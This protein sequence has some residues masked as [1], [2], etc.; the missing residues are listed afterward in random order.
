MTLKLFEMFAGYGG[1]SFALERLGL[2]YECIGYSEIDKNA[3]KCYNLNHPNRKNFG[4]CRSINP[5]E[6]PNFDLLTGGFPCQPFSVAGQNMGMNDCRG[7]LFYDIIRIVSVKHPKYILL[8]NVPGMLSKT[9]IQTFNLI[10][11]ML[12][13]QGY[14]VKWNILN[15]CDYGLPQVRKRIWIVC[16]RKDIYSSFMFP[17]VEFRQVLLESILDNVNVFLPTESMFHVLCDKNVIWLNRMYN[18]FVVPYNTPTIVH[19]SMNGRRCKTVGEPMFTLTTRDRHGIV[20]KDESGI[21]VR[22]LTPNECF[23]LMGFKNHQINCD[24]ISPSAQY[25]L[26]GNGWDINLVSKIFGA[27]L[28]EYK[29]E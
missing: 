8:E 20:I 10:L 29:H 18:T 23:K 28:K 2:E 6:L 17:S 13:E 19:K 24:G 5:N 3:I 11:S 22:L 4:D 27:L 26:A 12:E 15:T 25:R 9:H 16:I 7:T 21:H 1:A 14:I